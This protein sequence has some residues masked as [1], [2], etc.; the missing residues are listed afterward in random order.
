M[1]RAIKRPGVC[2]GV[3]P[4][5]MGNGPFLPSRIDERYP[6]L[7]D[8]MFLQDLLPWPLSVGEL[9]SVSIGFPD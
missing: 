3:R 6:G 2:P 1:E 8:P 5:G 7:G 9:G 4:G